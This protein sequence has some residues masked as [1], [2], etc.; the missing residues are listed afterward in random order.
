MH[1]EE[2]VPP[3]MVTQL[4]GVTQLLPEMVVRRHRGPTERLSNVEPPK[5]R[6]TE[7]RRETVELTPELMGLA[8][9]PRSG[10]RSVEAKEGARSKEPNLWK[11]VAF[12]MLAVVV[13]LLVAI[14]AR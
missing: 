12:V 13:A 6:A 10:L 5:P 9:S 3:R 11:L 7:R 1:E 2:P 8:M 14:A 4:R